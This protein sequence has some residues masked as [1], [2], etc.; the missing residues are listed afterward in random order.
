MRVS[1]HRRI[2]GFSATELFA[3]AEDVESYPEFLPFCIA[4]RI[5]ERHGPDWVVDNVFGVGPFRTRFTT[6]A[7]FQ[8]PEHIHITSADP[9]FEAL[10]IDWAFRDDGAGGCDVG[11][12]MTQIF[13]SKMRE[14]LVE[15]AS[16]DIEQVLI[17]R[18]EARARRVFK[19]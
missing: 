6:H 15:A 13:K 3:V 4:A 2:D 8:P 1:V 18:F 11:F 19:R 7:H 17:D 16:G 9:Q 5:V 12:E 10:S 14:R